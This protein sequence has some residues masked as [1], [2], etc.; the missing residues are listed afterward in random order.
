MR[1]GEKV[2]PMASRVFSIKETQF[3]KTELFS[4]KIPGCMYNRNI[5]PVIN[6]VAS[7]VHVSEIY[8]VFTVKWPAAQAE[9][10]K[11]IRTTNERILYVLPM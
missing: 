3:P 11:C 10:Y 6:P 7:L 2:L 9:D 8:I 4:C 1:H 5:T